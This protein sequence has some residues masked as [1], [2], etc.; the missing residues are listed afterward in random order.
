MTIKELRA[1]ERWLSDVAWE[2]SKAERD[3][4]GGVGEVNPRRAQR[5]AE[6]LTQVPQMETAAPWWF[7]PPPDP[8][9]CVRWGDG[10]DRCIRPFDHIGPCEDEAG[11]TTLTLAAEALAL[12]RRPW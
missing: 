11:N 6:L 10:A 1:L 12:V 3:G 2:V 5:I 9:L 7:I 8:A 4:D